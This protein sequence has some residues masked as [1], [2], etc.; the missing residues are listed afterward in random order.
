MEEESNTSNLICI[1]NIFTKDILQFCK[2]ITRGN[3][4]V[5]DEV[6][7]YLQLVMI[8]FVQVHLKFVDE[9]IFWHYQ[10]VFAL[11][12]CWYGHFS[13]EKCSAI[14][15]LIDRVRI[16]WWI[17]LITKETLFKVKWHLKF[18]SSVYFINIF[19]KNKKNDN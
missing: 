11:N 4:L 19:R 18:K 17:L 16:M 13:Y 14:T 5:K 10:K 12:V 15:K 3:K 8:D 7:K 2:Y 1:R 6:K 9:T